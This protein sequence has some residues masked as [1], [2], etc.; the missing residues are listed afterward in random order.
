MTPRPSFDRLAPVYR[1]L[2]R[3]T[4]GGL[5]HWCRTAHLD[6][7][8]GCRRALILGD[9]DGRFLADLLR[10]NPNV[11]VDSLDISPGMIALAR[12][13]IATIPGAAARVRFVAADAR[14]D[15]LPAIGYDL[16]VT[17][18]VLDCFRRAELAAVVRRVAASCAADAVWIDG[19]FRVPR[20]GWARPVARLAL[21]GMYAFFRLATRLPA[22]ALI[23]PA[24]LLAAEG[25]GCVSEV[26]RLSGFLSARLWT[27]GGPVPAF[28]LPRVLA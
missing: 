10:A 18:F 26:E 12:R 28:D 19:D 24:P 9:G 3:L 6:H 11:D 4:F 14:T 7:L 22:G 13:R 20:T 5:L 16:V 27:R 15:A 1:T 21:A 2:E 17:N 25:F 8:R 23:D